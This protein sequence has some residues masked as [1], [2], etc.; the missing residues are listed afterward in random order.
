MSAD[1]LLATLQLKDGYRIADIHAIWDGDEHELLTPYVKADFSQS[2][3]YLTEEEAE[4][5]K[6]SILEQYDKDM[7]VLEYG[8]GTYQLDMTWA[9][10]LA[11]GPHP[12]VECPVCC[13]AVRE[14][15]PVCGDPEVLACSDCIEGR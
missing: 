7:R 11:C 5:A 1:N 10:Y 9:E 6:E 13:M 12:R 4:A 8:C 2:Q 14:L 3:H 15:Q